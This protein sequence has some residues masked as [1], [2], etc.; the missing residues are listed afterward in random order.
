M[1]LI[2]GFTIFLMVLLFIYMTY[3]IVLAKGLVNLLVLCLQL[4]SITIAI[5]AFVNNVEAI[6]YVQGIYI[7]F[8]ITLPVSFLIYDYLNMV[9]RARSSGF[10]S[11]LVER[12][13]EKVNEKGFSLG[14]N[15]NYICGE[16]E[17][18]RIIKDLDIDKEKIINNISHQLNE[19]ET[20]LRKEE[21]KRAYEAYG[22]IVKIIN[23]NTGVWYN[24]ANICYR[25]GL[26][27]K[28]EVSY[29]KVLYLSSKNKEN[30]RPLVEKHL[31]FYNLGNTRFK[32]G[33]Y[34]QAVQSF[35]KAVH[36]NSDFKEA[37]E[38]LPFAIA[39]S[40]QPQEAIECF[41]NM[42]G[43]FENRSRVHFLLGLLFL[44]NRQ[45]EKSIEELKKCIQRDEGYKEAYIELGK[46]LVKTGNY[47]DAVDI[48]EKYTMLKPN[49]SDGYYYLGT[50]LYRLGL[51]D[52][53]IKNFKLLVD[54]DPKGYKGY[55]NLGICLDE[56]GRSGEAERAYK[57][58]IEVKPDFVGAYN[59]LG[60]LF[61]SQGKYK[62]AV[63]VYIEA[64]RINPKEYSLYYNLGVTLTETGKYAE[65]VDAYRNALSIKPDEYEICYHL[66][67]ALVQL[68]RFDEAVKAYTAALEIKPSEGELFYNLASVYSLL[69]K[70]DIAI[71]SLKRAVE[72]DKGFKREA[73]FDRSFDSI[74]SRKEFKELVS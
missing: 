19:A 9:K 12:R 48:L 71:S 11:V 7:L 58:V 35:K 73:R 25:L 36:C 41:E 42:A 55:Y 32:L 22:S 66:G 64:L 52:K 72:L 21:Y 56:I 50:S 27:E 61:S 47:K 62:E 13:R 30:G 20:F 6:G 33:K 5:I 45:Y 60:I 46:L 26:Y 49:D 29:K 31:V 10:N 40:G 44:Q 63:D 37:M 69:K 70:K 4:F 23:D 51:L 14:D 16:L 65:A 74:R 43:K 2:V 28:A 15:I 67:N 34:H 57:K 17:S 68:K 53:A 54:I 38:N 3:R 18:L 1:S 59:N 39:C 24:Y 8:G